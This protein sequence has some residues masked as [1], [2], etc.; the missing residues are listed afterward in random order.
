MADPTPVEHLATARL[1]LGEHEGQ[2][3][4]A[5]RVVAHAAIAQ[6]ASALD[7]RDTISRLNS[8]LDGLVFTLEELICAIGNHGT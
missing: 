1:I 7:L 5:E 6:A 4:A 8:R 2:M 3:T